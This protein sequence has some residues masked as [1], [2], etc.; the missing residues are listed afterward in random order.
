MSGNGQRGRPAFERSPLEQSIVHNAHVPERCKAPCQLE[1]CLCLIRGLFISGQSRYRCSVDAQ[2]N[3]ARRG[4]R[5]PGHRARGAACAARHVR[6]GRDAELA[7]R[8]ADAAEA[9]ESRTR[10]CSTSISSAARPTGA[11]GSLS[12]QDHGA[13]PDAAVVIITAHG[14]VSIAVEAIKRGAS[15]FVAKPWSNERLAATVRSAAAL[16][17]SR[18]DARIE[19]GRASELAHG[20]GD[21]AARRVAGDGAR[22]NADRARRPDRRQRPDPRRER[23]RQGDRRAR[24]PS[25]VAAQRQADGLDRPRRDQRNACSNPSCSATSRARSPALP[26]SASAGS[27]PPTTAPC[28]STRSATCRFT[29]NPSC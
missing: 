7:R 9:R 2:F 28:S 24:D 15:D 1:S 14:A 5:R 3:L 17:R 29:F 6:A 12:R 13:R 23:H 20:A 4:R 16:R 21:A 11:K 19:R 22:P 8:P 25:A 18:I 26:A 10:S 27:R